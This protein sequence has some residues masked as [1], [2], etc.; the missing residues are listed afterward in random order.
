MLALCWRMLC[1]VTTAAEHT[2]F[3]NKTLAMPHNMA[4]HGIRWHHMPININDRSSQIYIDLWRHF[5]AL[6]TLGIKN[7]VG[8]V[9]ACPGST[10]GDIANCSSATSCSVR[11]RGSHQQRSTPPENMVDH[12]DFEAYRIS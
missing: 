6:S 11:G 3:R 10:V 12:L 7:M 1:Q 9:E 8:I 5:F 4:S 2:N